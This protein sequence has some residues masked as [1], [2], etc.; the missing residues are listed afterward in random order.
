MDIVVCNIFNVCCISVMSKSAEASSV[1]I[2]CQRS[3][4]SNKAVDSHIKLLSSNKE[5]VDDVPL[6]DIGLSLWTFRFP[7]EIILPLSYLLEF[8]E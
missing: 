2:C 5:G 7:P 6:D 8:V 4:A 3:V 1:Q